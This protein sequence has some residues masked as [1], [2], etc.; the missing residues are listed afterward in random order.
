MM[1]DLLIG[2]FSNYDWRI[3]QYWANSIS[4]SGFTGDRAAI[5]YN[6]DKDT[7]SQLTASAFRIY[8]LDPERITCGFAYAFPFDVMLHRFFAYYE[9]IN[10]LTDI[11]KYRYVI[12]T[13]VTDVVLQSDPSVWLT[14]HMGDKK[15]CASCESLRYRDEP[16]GNDSLSRSYPLLYERIAHRPIWNAG[17]QAGDIRVM[18]DFWLHLSLAGAA[19]LEPADQATYNILLSLKPWSDIT[20]FTMG[21][22]GWACQVGTQVAENPN[23]LEPSQ[24]WDG[25]YST[26]SSGRRHVILH[27]YTRIPQWRDAVERAYFGSSGGS[28]NAIEPQSDSSAGSSCGI[29]DSD[30]EEAMSKT[31]SPNLLGSLVETSRRTFGF[32]TSHFPHI[33]NYPWIAAKLENLP[34]GSRVLDIG[35][36]VSPL[37]I[38]MAEKA[39]L[40]ETVDNHVNVRNLPA[41]D[42]WN[43]WG[44]FDYGQLHEGLTSHHCAI[45][46]F[47]PVANFDAIY[48]ICVLA[49]MP[50]AV[51]E[52]TL[53]RCREWLLPGGRLLLTIDLIPATDFLWN[54]SEDREVEPPVVHGTI[55]D[56]LDQLVILGFQVNQCR[57]LRTVYKSRTD[58][59]LIDCTA[60]PAPACRRRAR[61]RTP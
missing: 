4:R 60:T 55:S 16:W 43:E 37:P 57:T 33:V 47:T 12:A 30:L 27:Q 1:P 7:I 46:E 29:S 51:R 18:R 13:D 20:L 14:E 53:R 23:L 35:A 52:D 28:S 21:E 9:F 17:V 31:E 50:R 26:T 2:C 24:R 49:H 8:A 42:D 22:D 25:N 15:I 39:V 6:T 56:I 61:Y 5:V 10:S 36:G 41:A 54:R 11:D 45:S 58:L 32:F 38:W 40:V 19:A 48:S 59:L 3:V 44:F 34:A